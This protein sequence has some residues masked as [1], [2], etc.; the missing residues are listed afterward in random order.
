MLGQLGIAPDGSVRDKV[1]QKP[2]SGHVKDIRGN[3]YGMLVVREYYGVKVSSYWVCDCDCG[4]VIIASSHSLNGGNTTSCG[5]KHIKQSS[6]LC[7]ERNTTH[8]YSKE[9]LYSVW[10]TM[11][12]RCNNPAQHDYKWYG[13]KG[14]RVCKE[15]DDYAVFRAWAV[16][17]GY[18]RGLTIDR[19]NADG[20]Y[21]SDNCRWITIQ[22]QQRNKR[23]HKAQQ[24]TLLEMGAI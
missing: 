4:G 19:I 21:S 9:P 17:N 15:W 3:R 22:E 12:Q 10:K 16:A 5:C 2:M 1:V 20:N 23:I 18:K 13:A 14:V 8:G 6:D 11:R 7:K 24:S